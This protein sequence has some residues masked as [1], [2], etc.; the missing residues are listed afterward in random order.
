[1]VQLWERRH[2]EYQQQ[3]KEQHQQ[4]WKQNANHRPVTLSASFTKGPSAEEFRIYYNESAGALV[5]RKSTMLD[6]VH[7]SI[8]KIMDVCNTNVSQD[9]SVLLSGSSGIGVSGG[10]SGD[11]S[12]DMQYRACV[13]EGIANDM[14]KLSDSKTFLKRK[15][16]ANAQKLREYTCADLTMSTSPTIDS[17]PFETQDKTYQINVLFDTPAAKIMYTNNFVTDEECQVLMRHGKP[18]LKRAT[19][20]AEDGSSIVSENRKA[21]QASYTLNKSMNDPLG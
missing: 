11:N 14:V 1:M 18:R 15:H 2:S 17:Y 6:D 21:Q 19:V 7:Q 12:S 3:Q 5:V 16:V 8:N 4:Q 9:R 13:T 10:V 20:A